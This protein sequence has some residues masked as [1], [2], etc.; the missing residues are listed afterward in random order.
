MFGDLTIFM[1]ETFPRQGSIALISFKP[2]P[3]FS[4]DGC[5]STTSQKMKFSI[6]DFFGKCDQIHRKLRIWSH[7]LKK[8]LI[9]NLIFCAEYKN[10][11]KALEH[12]LIYRDHYFVSAIRCIRW[13]SIC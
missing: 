12:S 4:N 11:V 3:E 10:V 13:L 9:E 7:L 5:I 6:K 1:Y 2:S 8:Y